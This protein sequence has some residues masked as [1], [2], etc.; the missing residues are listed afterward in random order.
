MK[1]CKQVKGPGTESKQVFDMMWSHMLRITLKTAFPL[2]CRP[3]DCPGEKNTRIPL[4]CQMNLEAAD[5]NSLWEADV[6]WTRAGEKCDSGQGCI[7]VKWWADASWEAGAGSVLQNTNHF[8]IDHC[9]RFLTTELWAVM[10]KVEMK[11]VLWSKFLMLKLQ[12]FF[13]TL[14]QAWEVPNYCCV[15]ATPDGLPHYH[16]TSSSFINPVLNSYVI[17]W[18]A[19]TTW[20]GA[21]HAFPSGNGGDI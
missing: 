9:C 7:C 4:L 5:W 11:S 20:G 2:N 16:C 19:R 17:P 1:T 6:E 3:K 13:L 18:N 8:P 15:W 14:W 21:S 10:D 12:L